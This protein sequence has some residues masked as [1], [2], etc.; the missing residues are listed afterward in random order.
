MSRMNSFDVAGRVDDTSLLVGT[1]V[2]KKVAS[3]KN[4]RI[5]AV[6]RFI[7]AG[8]SPE[9]GGLLKYHEISYDGSEYSKPADFVNSLVPTV[10]VLRYHVLVVTMNEDKYLFTRQGVTIGDN[11]DV[12]E[13]EDF[14]ALSGIS[15]GT[16]RGLISDL[17]QRLNIVIA[18]LDL[19][20]NELDP[21]FSSLT[22]A[23]NNKLDAETS[24]INSN[25]S[26]LASALTT[27]T[28]A[29]ADLEISLNA[30]IEDEA[31]AR[32][33]SIESVY[34]A[35]V[36]ETEARAELKTELEASI[37]N[38]TTER[39]ASVTTLQQAL[40]TEAESRATL[41]TQ[42]NAAI[43]TESTNRQV[44][45]TTLQQALVT[46][47]QAIAT[48]GTNLTAA[49]NTEKANREAAVTTLQQA[50]VT[51]SAARATLA[52][53]LT[54][55]INTEK[56][57]R[58]AAI[59]TLQQADVTESTARATLGTTL[60][61]AINTEKTN[62]EAAVATLQQAD[63]TE[64][65]A[66][67]TLGTNLTAAINTEASNRAAAITTLNTAIA[68]ETSSRASAI[69]SLNTTVTNNFNTLSSSITNES[70]ART[71]AIDSIA[72]N[73]NTLASTV[74]GN[75]ASITT[76]QETI[77]NVDGKLSASYGL[78]V[79]ANGRI[80]SMKLL[81]NGVSSEVAFKADSFKIF[82]G[83]S[84]V[85][86]FI[87]ENGQVKMTGV[88][89][90]DTLITPGNGPAFPAAG[91]N[92]LSVNRGN[93][94]ALRFRHANGTV[95]IEI[96]IIGGQLTLNWYNDQGV[97]VWKGGSDGI[98]YINNIPES[99]TAIEMGL[100]SSLGLAASDRDLRSAALPL[101][102]VINNAGRFPTN[103]ITV[104]EYNAGQNAFASANRQYEAI[105][106]GNSYNTARIA[107]G[108]YGY[109]TIN[110]PRSCDS[111]NVCTVNLYLTYIENGV[112][113]GNRA[114][115]VNANNQ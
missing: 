71:T 7:L 63:V 55:A 110:I 33:A 17:E 97:L 25:V 86:P 79:D 24:S 114:I 11:M 74:D 18:D 29:R 42:L 83:T 69:T 77:A 52:T 104:Y 58:E 98:T 95:G 57:N 99:Y 72:T 103:F 46:E 59:T 45:V 53:N 48:L 56:T 115:T 32:S 100:V 41:S 62:R 50:D 5:D 85:A 90:A 82:N 51:E 54:A 93:D 75:T 14:I 88:T 19:L 73:I 108:W 102:E 84:N 34:T 107:T 2:S 8:L 30:R 28:E 61:A 47:S 38:E 22:T 23:L 10:D 106:V 3:I 12:V 6:R 111:S 44:A 112:I 37:E 109:R 64:S 1:E 27:E 113:A 101:L 16:I 81:S 67:A 65:Q 89:T 80:A 4:Y 31:S 21:R 60:N 35:L 43:T 70:S 40:V 105:Y 76:A 68:N 94:N 87:V 66:R 13:D 92:G 78:S 49:I 96:G 26:I 39:T 15:A 20:E 91:W 9:T 36:N